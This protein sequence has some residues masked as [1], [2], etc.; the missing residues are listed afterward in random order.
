MGLSESH[1]TKERRG[2]AGLRGAGSLGCSVSY[3]HGK[4]L[5]LLDWVSGMGLR[6]SR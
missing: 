3:L 5:V 6:H 1:R 2:L 4:V